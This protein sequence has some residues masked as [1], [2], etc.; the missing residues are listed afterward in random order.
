MTKA[1]RFTAAIALVITIG[2]SP[3][4]FAAITRGDDPSI[5]ARIVR[6]F[7][8]ILKPIL[9]ISTHDDPPPPDPGYTPNPT[10][11]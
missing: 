1:R 8:R 10:R 11:P 9:P 3:A 7:E 5:G 6:F 4:S 2:G